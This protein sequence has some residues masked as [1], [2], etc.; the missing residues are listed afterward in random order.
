VV[1]P[2]RE[3]PALEDPRNPDEGHPLKGFVLIREKDCAVGGEEGGPTGRVGAVVSDRD[4]PTAKGRFPGVL[5]GVGTR[6]GS[7]HGRGWRGVGGG[8]GAGRHIEAGLARGGIAQVREGAG[9]V[10]PAGAAGDRRLV[11]AQVG[12]DGRAGSAGKDRTEEPAEAA[13]ELQRT[14]PRG[15]VGAG[16]LDDPDQEIDGGAEDVLQEW[17]VTSCGMNG[18]SEEVGHHVA[19][20]VEGLIADTVAARSAA[21]RAENVTEDAGC[22]GWRDGSHRRARAKV[23]IEDAVR[24]GWQ[25]RRS[26]PDVLPALP[27]DLVHVRGLLVDTARGVAHSGDRGKPPKHHAPDAEMLRE[28]GAAR[29]R[30]AD[31]GLEARAALGR[32]LQSPNR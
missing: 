21:A 11:G 24:S 27:K 10:R 25:G 16:S 28:G 12:L 17:R 23:E 13:G 9:D 29:A 7:G 20:E 5:T 8:R 31:P 2:R 26:P 4:A 19:G 1:Q 6:R 22:R 32:R 3:V 15:C 30:A 14:E 18:L